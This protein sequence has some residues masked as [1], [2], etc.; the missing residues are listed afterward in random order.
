MLF[1]SEAGYILGLGEDKIALPIEHNSHYSTLGY[2]GRMYYVHNVSLVGLF[3]MAVRKETL[4]E[5]GGFD[6]HYE[7]AYAGFDLCLKE[8]KK[9]KQVAL[10]PY[11]INYEYEKPLRMF[12]NKEVLEKDKSYLKTRW[13]EILA[14]G[15]PYY[16]KNLAKDGSFTYD[17]K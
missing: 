12:E 7:T 6:E 10:D 17:Y 2:M 15:D 3:G 16:N 1:R 13:E 9:G 4:C 8:L 11:V 5:E 14:G